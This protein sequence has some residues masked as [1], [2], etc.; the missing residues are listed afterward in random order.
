[1]STSDVIDNLLTL[2]QPKVTKKKRKQGFNEKAVCITDDDVLK[3]LEKEKEE[4]EQK[5][6]ETI[7]KRIEREKRREQ[8][9]IETAIRQ[10]KKE[11]R[12]K[13]KKQH[14]RPKSKDK[15]IIRATRQQLKRQR[16]TV[17]TPMNV[18][19]NVEDIEMLKICS[20]TEE[21]EAECPNV[22]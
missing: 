16:V 20:D 14:L 3:E 19:L 6:E 4:K 2:P 11:E 7:A 22:E 15:Q 10:K 13:S 9:K 1:M 17:K 21:S 5:K 12:K 8:K 18:E